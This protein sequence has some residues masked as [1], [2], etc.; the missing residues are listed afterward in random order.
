MSLQ[1]RGE[2]GAL[3]AGP[4]RTVDHGETIGAEPHLLHELRERAVGAEAAQLIVELIE[5]RASFAVGKA[6]EILRARGV[7][8]ILDQIA[9]ERQ[10]DRHVV[11]DDVAHQPHEHE[12]DRMAERLG[13]A[14][15]AAVVVRV[16]V[17]ELMQ[18]A[19]GEETFPRAGRIVPAHC[20]LEHAGKAAI[21]MGGQIASRPGGERIGGCGDDLE[22]GGLVP[23]EPRVQLGDD[24]EIG[25]Q[26][27][28]LGG[29]A[30]VQLRALVD[31]ERLIQIV[32]LHAQ[33]VDAVAPFVQRQ[34]VDQRIAGGAG[35]EQAVAVQAHLAG[36]LRIA[37]P[38]QHLSDAPLGRQIERRL[39]LADPSRS[40][41]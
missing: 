15:G 3:G 38:A 41:W 16:E 32:G 17:G 35:V 37:Q 27:A 8:P 9:R 7:G 21:G 13:D 31:V 29:R 36:G 10:M 26:G 39:H 22:L 28:Q 5:E 30:E 2:L 24:L 34:A 25:D 1:K 40:S 20:R 33:I 19:A 4:H 12:V 18:A 11:P 6:D 14:H 23:A